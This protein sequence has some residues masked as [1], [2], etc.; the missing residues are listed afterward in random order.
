MAIEGAAWLGFGG[1][2]AGAA[3]GFASATAQESIRRRHE[4][5]R[6]REDQAREDA[7]RFEERRFDAYVALITAATRCYGIARFQPRHTGPTPGER[8]IDAAYEHFVATLSPAFLMASTTATRDRLA[9]VVAT[10]R[11]LHEAVTADADAHVGAGAGG[12]GGDAAAGERP[13]IPALLKEH[14]R[15]IRTAEAAMRDEF[16]L[17][18]LPSPAPAAG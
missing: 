13:D 4:L 16:G 12:E 18:P 5:R 7:V 3:L 6:R 9:E 10:V 17:P 8:P 1:V 15:A 11:A 2:V 14:R